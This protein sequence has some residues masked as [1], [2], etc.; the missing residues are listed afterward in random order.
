MK[1]LLSGHPSRV[2]LPALLC[3]ASLLFAQAPAD[4]IWSSIDEGKPAAEAPPAP[5]TDSP[6]AEP[7]SAPAPES[8]QAAA[9]EENLPRGG[10]G[11]AMRT[12][13]EPAPAPVPEAAAPAAETAPEGTAGAPAAPAGEERTAENA[14]PADGADSTGAAETPENAPAAEGGTVAEAD[15]AARDTVAAATDE[16]AEAAIAA[17]AA[18]SA[19]IADRDSAAAK[20]QEL[21]GTVKVSQVGGVTGLE[22]YRSPR[23]ALFMSLLV[24]GLGQ[25]YVGGAPATY[26]RGGVYVALEATLI[27]C[28]WT[29]GAGAYDDKVSEARKWRKKNFSDSLYEARTRALYRQADE[30]HR[31]AFKNANLAKRA[32]WCDALYSESQESERKTCTDKMLTDGFD[33]HVATLAAEGFRPYDRD[34]YEILLESGDFVL[35]WKDTRSVDADYTTVFRTISSAQHDKYNKLRGEASDA[36][37]LETLFLGGILLNH[38]ASAVDAVLTA[39]FHNQKLYEREA[40]IASRLQVGGW[41]GMGAS[42]WENRVQ[43]SLTF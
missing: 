37:D 14:A 18:D 42:G 31:E 12:E 20:R 38:I 22:R 1:A 10:A 5:G 8:A 40:G 3:A 21:L 4:D 29:L 39:H 2:F 19:A 34:A 28:W 24:P 13:P 27:A 43:L 15:S 7:T 16:K 11:R 35:G 36:A 23:K 30:D 9:P 26:V 25:F 32:S 41:S 33:N 17:A 6:A